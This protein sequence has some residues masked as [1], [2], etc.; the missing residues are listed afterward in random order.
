MSRKLRVI[1]SVAVLALW[2]SIVVMAGIHLALP[3]WDR[4]PAF[5]MT[6]EV[7]W[8]GEGGES[9]S[10]YRFVYRD[11]SSWTETL[12]STPAG[13]VGRLSQKG[14]GYHIPG[15]WFLPKGS[16]IMRG[17][18]PRSATVMTAR[19]GSEDVVT[20]VRGF[21]RTEARFDVATGIP[22][23]YEWSFAGRMTNRFEV[24]SLV[25]ATGER[26]R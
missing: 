14:R 15:L 18:W 10:V 13:Y 6:R 11:D 25:L 17:A 5:E 1:A 20:I 21:G 3:T 9:T 2:A 4:Y 22:L 12:V 7:T 26:I 23:S 24:T 16:V 8:I 19:V